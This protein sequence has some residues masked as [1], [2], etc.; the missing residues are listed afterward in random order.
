MKETTSDS[1]EFELGPLK[2]LGTE[3]KKDKDMICTQEG[4]MRKKI[5]VNMRTRRSK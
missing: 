3:L 4:T 2:W 5:E 1:A